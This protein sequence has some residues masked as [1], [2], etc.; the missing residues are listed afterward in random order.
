LLEF[1]WFLVEL[2][3]E[4]MA[5]FE[6]INHLLRNGLTINLSD[7][8]SRESDRD[9]LLSRL[10]QLKQTVGEI[11][12]ALNRIKSG[13]YGKCVACKRWI[14]MQRLEVLPTAKFCLQCQKILEQEKQK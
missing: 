13:N 6:E 11:H 1:R 7:E 8:T 4:S 5:R 9:H 14:S 12:Q 10:E 3:K 2:L